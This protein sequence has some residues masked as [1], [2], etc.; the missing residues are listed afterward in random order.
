MTEAKHI[1]LGDGA[2]AS[3]DGWG[4]TL[5]ANHHETPT[6]QV[7]LEPNAIIS[8]VRFAREHKVIPEDKI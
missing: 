8:L 6:D 4:L 3:F 2:Y 5:K 1:H 7:F